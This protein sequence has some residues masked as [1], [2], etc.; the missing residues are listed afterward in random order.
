MIIGQLIR[1]WKNN[2]QPG[3]RPQVELV[4]VAN[5]VETLNKREFN[6]NSQIDQETIR[7]YIKYWKR[8]GKIEGRRELIE[9]I[10]PNLY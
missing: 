4:F 1:R 2:P 3:A 10:C 8:R 9:S 7:S 5:S 6:S